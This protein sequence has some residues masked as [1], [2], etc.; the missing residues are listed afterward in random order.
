MY[1]G[2][3]LALNPTQTFM[4]DSQCLTGFS[5]AIL[6]QQ[7]GVNV[8]IVCFSVCVS[9]LHTQAIAY[10]IFGAMEGQ[11]FLCRCILLERRTRAHC[12]LS[13]KQLC[14]LVQS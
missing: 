4:A 9:L 11:K 10:V 2:G 13:L 1:V 7:S 12:S 5:A 6:D 3:T 8:R 14:I